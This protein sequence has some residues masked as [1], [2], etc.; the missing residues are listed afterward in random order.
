MLA[1]GMCR[2]ANSRT[3]FK[4]KKSKQLAPTTEIAD[5]YYLVDYLMEE[6]ILS[7]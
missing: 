3:A 5:L 4:E 1:I 7:R 6:R 2:A